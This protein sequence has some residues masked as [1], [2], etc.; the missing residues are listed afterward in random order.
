M[1][2]FVCYS[3]FEEMVKLI[4]QILSVVCRV[5]NGSDHLN[6]IR[7]GKA[8]NWVPHGRYFTEILNALKSRHT[9]T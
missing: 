3:F 7:Y 2:T 4:K 5:A 6:E 1:I 9:R 8:Q